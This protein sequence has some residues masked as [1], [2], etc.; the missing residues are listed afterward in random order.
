MEVPRGVRTRSG[1]VSENVFCLGTHWGRPPPT[2]P[3]LGGTQCESS[4]GSDRQGGSLGG[5]RWGSTDLFLGP[6]S[7]P[8]HPSVWVR[9][10]VNRV[11]LEYVYLSEE[12][13]GSRIRPRLRCGG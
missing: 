9:R 1:E 6:E 2:D 13:F 5:R 3:V 7:S 4:V 11:D 8:L 10:P 12:D